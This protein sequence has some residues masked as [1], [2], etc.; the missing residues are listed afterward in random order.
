MQR[1][2]WPSS[3]RAISLARR[4]RVLV[5]QALGAQRDAGNAEAALETR[6]GHEAPGDQVALLRGKALESHDLLAVSLLGGHGAGRQ[7]AAVDQRQAAAALPLG[8]ASVLRRDH[9]AA[10]AQHFEQAL[11]RRDPD[12][13]RLSVEDERDL[14]HGLTPLLAARLPTV[15]ERCVCLRAPYLRRRANGKAGRPPP[16]ARS[17]AS[18]RLRHPN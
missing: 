6:R 15:P 17:R 8:L 12:A 14:L 18:R 9:T 16:P 5:E 2:R 7:R 3:A 11:P 10:V 4:A 13:P 1:H